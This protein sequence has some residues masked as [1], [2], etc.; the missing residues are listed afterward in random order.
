MSFSQVCPRARSFLYLYALLH[1]ATNLDSN[2][3]INIAMHKSPLARHLQIHA[4]YATIVHLGVVEHPLAAAFASANTL[5]LFFSADLIFCP[6]LSMRSMRASSQALG[7]FIVCTS[8]SNA[9]LTRWLI[10]LGRTRNSARSPPSCRRLLGKS[11]KHVCHPSP[12]GVKQAYTV[13]P[14][15][16]WGNQ[17]DLDLVWIWFICCPDR[18]P[19]ST[20]N[21]AFM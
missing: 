13:Q 18:S 3:L 10:R 21:R 16:G 6:F 14:T 4:N 5:S 2:R 17:A 1:T 12:A 11:G 7:P 19:L 15:G 8:P 20:S 9:D